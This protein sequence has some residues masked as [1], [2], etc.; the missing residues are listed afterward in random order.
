MPVANGQPTG[1]P[2]RWGLGEAAGAFLVG[3]VLSTI[4]GQ[5]GAAIVNY[6]PGH[7]QPIPLA[8]SVSGLVGLWVGLLGGVVFTSRTRGSGQ[9]GPDFG[10]RLKWPEDVGI[11]VIAGL[12]SQYVLVPLLYLP[13]EQFDPSLRHRLQAP[14]KQDT[15]AVHGALQI[16]I[17]FLFLAVGA[18]LVEELFFRG[19]LQRSLARRFGP[20]VAVC[21]SA[22]I[23][24]LAHFEPLQLPALILFGLVLGLLAQRTGRLGPGIV[25]HATF[26]AV[27]V[28]TLTLGK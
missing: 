15:G 1:S 27:T 9:L 25:A 12:A 3:I 4:T 18:P 10:F 16:T 23:F 13:F 28:L 26:N 2:A 7:H 5:I 8:V 20:V 21:G 22:T 11:G 24:G 6:Q 17:L 14:A 19:L